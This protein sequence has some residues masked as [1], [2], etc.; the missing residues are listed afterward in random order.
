MPSES[1]PLEA[2]VQEHWFQAQGLRAP[3]LALHEDDE[4]A[5]LDLQKTTPERRRMFY[6]R[7]GYEAYLVLQNALSAAGR[8]LSSVPALLDFAC[9]YGRVLR[10]IVQA[11]PP[12]AVQASD[13][14][15][16]AVEFVQEAFSVKGFTSR[17]KAADIRFP[18]KYAL[19]CV[20]S[21]F[22]HL[23]RESFKQYLRVLYD[24]L[25]PDGLLLFST[26]T[27]VALSPSE[28]DPSGF[29]YHS[30]S[31]VPYLDP[32]E[33]GSAF[34]VPEAVR[35]ICEEVG[36]AHLYTL[37]RELWRIQDVHVA[38]RAPVPGLLSWKHAPVVRGEIGRAHV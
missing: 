13:I 22:S 19:I 18:R 27:P 37:E 15:P 1:S 30:F 21:L 25:E 9:G 7:T 35:S 4:M 14:L 16:A 20:F 17:V 6:M 34:V 12:A 23:P 32:S 24:Q 5:R 2:Q 3:N 36:I 8:P 11:A 29:T 10:F 26:L 28:R 33:Y 31:G 38:A